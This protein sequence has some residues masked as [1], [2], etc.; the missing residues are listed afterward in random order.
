M[1]STP[2]AHAVATVDNPVEQGVLGI[3]A[4]FID[5]FDGNW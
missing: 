5:T 1:G 3:V 4:V 2:H